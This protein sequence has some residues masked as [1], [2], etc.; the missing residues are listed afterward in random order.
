MSRYE[1]LKNREIAQ[2]LGISTT[3]VEKHISKALKTISAQLAQ[4]YGTCLVLCLM[5][6]LEQAQQII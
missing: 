1:S 5:L 6:C 3:A 2:Q 4:K